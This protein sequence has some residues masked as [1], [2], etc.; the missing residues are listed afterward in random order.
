M[1]A[2]VKTGDL[3]LRNILRA[4]DALIASRSPLGLREIKRLVCAGL[5]LP[6]QEGLQ[7]ERQAL[8]RVLGSADY[9]E[10]LAAF[11][12]RRKPKFMGQ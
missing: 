5:K 4:A 1:P 10:E 9:S 11:A 7:H 6:L 12:E 8:V 2:I 3:R